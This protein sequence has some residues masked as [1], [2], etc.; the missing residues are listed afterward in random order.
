[1]NS[2]MINGNHSSN[3]G[4]DQQQTSS[5]CWP[6]DVG[7]RALDIYFPSQYV[8]QTELEVYDGVSS[9]K[10]TKGLGQTRMGFCSDRE[11]IV[12]ICLTVVEKLMTR[13]G[14]KYKDI[15]RL[16][17]GTE[18]LI[19]KSKSVKSQLMQLFVESG[20]S[21]VEGV[22][23][24]NAC[25]GGTAALFNSV[26]W[27]ESRDWD[28][29]LAL[30]VCGDIAAY[31][32]GAAR[33]TG[34]AGAVA[35]LIGPKASLVLDRGIRSSHSEDKYDFYKPNLSSEYPTVDGP[36]S[37]KCYFK[38]LDKCYGQY[39]SKV[40]KQCGKNVDLNS[41]DAILFHSPFCKLVQKSLAK[42]AFNDFKANVDSDMYSESL[43][44]KFAN[45][46][47]EDSYTNKEVEIDFMDFSKNTFEAKTKPSLML[48]TNV[49]NMYTPSLY[50]GL[51]SFICSHEN[52]QDMVGKHVALFSYGSGLVSSF[53]SLVVK[54][55]QGFEDL[56][57]NFRS[58]VLT[59]LNSR[60]KADPEKFTEA[61]KLREDFF[62]ETLNILSATK[63][64]E[65]NKNKDLCPVGSIAELFPSTW[66]L[67]SVDDKLRRKYLKTDGRHVA[68]TNGTSN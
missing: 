29:R 50:G 59:R 58:D 62:T 16:E 37:I 23:S 35:M 31:A 57:D 53:F 1:M 66:Y 6:E 32:P 49:G 22:D 38:A 60:R 10:Y 8:D 28:G 5:R 40:K 63:K 7:I 47:L 46:T 67:E 65:E 14:T 13:T 54:P 2:K 15:G 61:M 45:V 64:A 17:V 21:D 41:F 3:N 12:S 36:L 68:A 25:Y 26:A 55:N 43:R 20:N 4:L 33:P 19:D 11:D 56:H 39:K 52:A 34:G 24:T 44:T 42:L 27:I 30:A 9:G 48:A 51:V 18:T